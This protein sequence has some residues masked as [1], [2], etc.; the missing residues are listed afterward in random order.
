M[1]LL[2]T[3]LHSAAALV[4]EQSEEIAEKFLSGQVDIESFLS[5]YL[6]TRSVI[7]W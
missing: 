6:P 7:I 1:L 5:T 4:D 3:N 2:Q